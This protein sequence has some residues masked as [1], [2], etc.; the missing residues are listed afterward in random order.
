MF[1]LNED[2][3]IYVTRGD[4]VAFAVSADYGA[5]KY[6]F[7]AGDVV[8]FKVTGKKNCENVVLQKDFA[9]EDGTDTVAILLT[10]QDT[11]IGDVISK[12]TDYWYEVELNPNT[13]PQTIIG[14]DEDGAKIFRLYPEGADIP[15]YE[16]TPEEIPVVDDELRVDSTRPVQN[17][18]IAR[19]IVQLTDLVGTAI[20]RTAEETSDLRAEMRELRDQ[21]I[22]DGEGG[23]EAQIGEIVEARIIEHNGNKGAHTEAFAAHNADAK[24][25]S[26]MFA[27]ASHTHT[28]YATVIYY[29]ASI[30]PIMWSADAEGGYSAT[31]LVEGMTAADKPEVDVL[32]TYNTTTNK[33]VKE[34]WACIDRV[35]AKDGAITLWGEVSEL[36]ADFDFQI[37]AVR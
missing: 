27:T 37:K 3:S 9:A 7:K 21:F 35:I 16:P 8:R 13:D 36:P 20:E 25:H 22:V 12:P 34:A 23:A 18:A 26:G 4:I 5:E 29:T 1:T 32:L 11:K 31:V 33:A 15:P 2:K 17:Q 24:A 19:A 6:T 28:E 10:E 14:Y 30:S